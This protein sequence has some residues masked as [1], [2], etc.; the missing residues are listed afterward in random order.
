[1]ELNDK[2]VWV[3][4]ASSGIGK[5]IAIELSFHKANLV[6]MSRNVSELKKTADACNPNVNIIIQP[7]DLADNASI[8]EAVRVLLHDKKIP[9]HILINNGGISQRATALDT[10]DAVT[11]KIFDINFFGTVYLTRALLPRMIEMGGARIAVI[12][13]LVGIIGSPKRTSYSASKHALHGYFDSLR[14]ELYKEQIGVTLICPG[15]IRT[16]ISLSAVTGDGTAQNTMDE[17]TGNG[18][19]P[20]KLAKIAVRGIMREKEEIY[21]GGKEILAIYLKRFVPTIFSKIL[22]K[23]KVT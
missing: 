10:V 15:F 23:T 7:I 8:D 13:S 18:M 14:A 9:P 16:N 5:A 1:M 6:L 2:W 21:I 20:A 11:R 17:K 19:D 22:R 12:T 4:G 3:T